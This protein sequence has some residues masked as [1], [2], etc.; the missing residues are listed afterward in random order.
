MDLSPKAQAVISLGQLS[1]E[2]GMIDR[3]SVYHSDGTPESDTDHTVMLGWIGCALAA[4]YFPNLDVGLV[5]QFALIHDA[6]EVYAGDTPTLRITDEGRIAKAEREAVAIERLNEE[7]SSFLPWVSEVLVTYEAQILPEARFV[8]GLDK[9][10]PKIVHLL[11]NCRGL[12]EQ[13]VSSEE[14]RGLFDRQIKSIGEYIGD[15]PELMSLYNELANAVVEL[16]YSGINR[17]D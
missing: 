7:Y 14:L 6:P 10:L 8:R 1:L 11:D 17:K 9:I 5:A 3:T 12:H 2:F 16:H 15:F 4:R 13:G